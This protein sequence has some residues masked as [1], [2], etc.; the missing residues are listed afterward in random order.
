[1]PKGCWITSYGSE[2]DPVAHADDAVLAGEAITAFGGRF[3]ARGS[4]SRAILDR[5]AE[6]EARKPEGAV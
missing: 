3:L 6:R 5:A 4:P 1:M 2:V